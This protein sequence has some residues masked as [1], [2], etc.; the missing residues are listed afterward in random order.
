ME[1]PENAFR[2]GIVDDDAPI[3]RSME[4]LLNVAGY[5][6]DAYPGPQAFLQGLPESLP[7]ALVVDL[8]MPGMTGLQLQSELVTRGYN[9]PL[10][11]LSAYGTVPASVSAMRGGAVDFLEKPAEPE[12]LLQALQRALAVAEGLRSEA[13]EQR[14]AQERLSL[15]S[16]RERDVFE[17]M[18]R[19]YRSKNIAEEL[20][21]ALQTV[22]VHR[23]RVMQKLGA[24][25]LTDLV[26][27]SD[28][29]AGVGA[30]AGAVTAGVS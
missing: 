11:F 16:P 24:R 7:D 4:R 20:G 26:R 8:Q 28:A 17:L 12:V 23:S 25:S 21:I 22:K 2:I 30:G 15:I 1:T 27:L 14:Q 29:A 19:G 18:V 10:V 5:K 9:I 6:V 3:L 13:A